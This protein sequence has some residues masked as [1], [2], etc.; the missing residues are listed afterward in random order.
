MAENLRRWLSGRGPIFKIRPSDGCGRNAVPL[1]VGQWYNFHSVG[2]HLGNVGLYDYKL[3]G[4]G[5]L[6]IPFQ[7]LYCYKSISYATGESKIMII[8]DTFNKLQA[9]RLARECDG[10]LG[11]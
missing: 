9:Q 4:M 10:N 2:C 5:P 8:I 6:L 3:S 1:A 11:Q 7:M